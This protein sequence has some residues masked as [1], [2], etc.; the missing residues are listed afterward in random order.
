MKYSFNLKDGNEKPFRQFTWFLFFL[1][2]TAAG[3]FALNTNESRV[4]V[5]MIVLLVFYALIY[6]VYSF[7]RR[8][9]KA[10]ETFSLITAFLYGHFWFSYVNTVAGIIFVVVFI[11][12]AMVQFRKTAIHISESGVHLTRIFKTVIFPWGAMTNV[13]LKDNILTIDFKTNRIIQVEIS[14]NSESVD[15]DQFNLFCT[16]QML[17]QAG[18]Q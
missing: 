16:G 18:N 2:L 7:Y 13:I 17:N 4:R 12:I 1:H 8:Y 15:E 11:F 3:I 14:E 6:I 9:R 5:G 10:L